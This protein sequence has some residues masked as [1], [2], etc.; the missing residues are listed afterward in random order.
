MAA[1]WSLFRYADQPLA[2]EFLAQLDRD[3][4]VTVLNQTPSPFYQLMQADRRA[5]IMVAA[6]ALRY[7]MFGGEAL[8]LAQLD[9]WYRSA[10]RWRADSSIMYG[11]DRDDGACQLRALDQPTADANAGSPDWPAD[12]E[13]AGLRLGR[14]AWSLY[15]LG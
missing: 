7:V 10:A 2:V 6:L 4:G 13:H 5:P 9:A 1:V 8:E 11:T 3:E 12:L 14:W 15:R